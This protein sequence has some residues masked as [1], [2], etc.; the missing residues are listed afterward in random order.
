[1]VKSHWSERGVNK[2]KHVTCKN[3]KI[4]WSKQEDS[5]GPVMKTA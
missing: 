2:H 1:L 4:A 5:A 3:F